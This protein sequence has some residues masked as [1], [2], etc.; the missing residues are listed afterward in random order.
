MKIVILTGSEVR[1]TFMRKAIGLADGVTVLR[2]YCEGTENGL[3]D[4]VR[5]DGA[6][7]SARKAHLHTRH[8]A[9]TDFFGAFVSLTSDLSAPLH[10]PRGTINDPV[11]TEEINNLAPDLLVA[12]GCSLI[13]DPLLSAFSGRFL[14]VHLGLSPYFRGSG[15][16]FWPLVR[17]H[18][19]YVGATFMHLDAGI[20]TGEIIHQIRAR[21]EP[22]DNPH[23]IGNRLIR[24]VALVYP[25][26]IRKFHDLPQPPPIPE[27]LEQHVC[28]KR[29][30]DEASVSDL[31]DAFDA[32][33]V[34]RYVAE[35]E[36]R[37]EAVPIATNPAI[38][39][40]ETLMA[41]QL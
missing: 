39:P 24:D 32:G 38:A 33:L 5:K 20:D 21:V 2:T 40:P 41:A 19:E 6:D 23:Q 4:I 26:I 36:K 31:Y 3:L 14:N 37:C 7:S 28:R 35:R 30:F 25:E 11:R 16:N 15:T 34:D 8:V 12:Y 18:P 13:R 1:H 9:E 27:P 10:L 22:G 29:D 17:G